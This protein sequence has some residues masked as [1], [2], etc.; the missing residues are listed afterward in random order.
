M[1][2][3]L[4]FLYLFTFHLVLT[5][6][7]DPLYNYDVTLIGPLNTDKHHAEQVTYYL[8]YFDYLAEEVDVW[9]AEVKKSLA[10]IRRQNRKRIAKKKPIRARD[11]P[12]WKRNNELLESLNDDAQLV[13]IYFQKWANYDIRKPDSVQQVF[14]ERFLDKNC[15]DLISAELVLAPDEYKI[16]LATTETN[17]FTWKEFIPK[18]GIRCPQAYTDNGKSCERSLEIEL[19][20][21]QQSKDFFLITNLLSDLPFHLDGFKQISCKGP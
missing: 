9:R 13:Q 5:A 16:N 1:K 3:G 2:I 10:I 12:A 18:Q 20:T 14:K 11:Y 7:A 4:S 17:F 21:P 6:Q 8:D 19:E 15:Y